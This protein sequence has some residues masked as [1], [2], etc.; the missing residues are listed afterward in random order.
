MIDYKQLDVASLTIEDAQNDP[1]FTKTRADVVRY[2]GLNDSFM[3]SVSDFEDDELIDFLRA[4]AEYYV[5]GLMPEYSTI[6]S[7][8]VRLALRENIA[9]HSARVDAAYL[10]SYKSFV[11][12]KKRKQT[13]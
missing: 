11:R 4:M 9:S 1:G 12:G 13:D 10:D 8:A 5:D 6:E 2:C 7:T 3:R